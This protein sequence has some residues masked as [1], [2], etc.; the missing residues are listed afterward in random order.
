[1]L[2]GYGKF[3]PKSLQSS[4]LAQRILTLWEFFFF[5]GRLGHVLILISWAVCLATWRPRIINL[6][7][8]LWLH[9][10]IHVFVVID[11]SNTHFGRV[12]FGYWSILFGYL[13]KH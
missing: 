3:Q 12:A 13:Y 11:E 7:Y 9:G 5:L 1:M 2:F 4:I 6:D 8:V 10:A